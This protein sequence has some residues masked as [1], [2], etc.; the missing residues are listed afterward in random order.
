MKDVSPK[1][2]LPSPL[3]TPQRNFLNIANFVA[4]V[5]AAFCFGYLAGLFGSVQLRSS[6]FKLAVALL[7]VGIA[8]QL[9]FAAVTARKELE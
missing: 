9:L 3:N 5:I 1:E 6:A 8:F 4:G 7:G 2:L